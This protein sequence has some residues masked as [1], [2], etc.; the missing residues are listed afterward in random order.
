VSLPPPLPPQ[1]FLLESLGYLEEPLAA[2]AL[3]I[4]LP[5]LIEY[6]KRGIGPDFAV[7]GR[8]IL[9]SHANLQTWLENGGTRAFEHGPTREAAL[10]ER[11]K[12]RK[13]KTAKAGLSTESV[14]VDSVQGERRAPTSRIKRRSAAEVPP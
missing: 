8:T 2:I 7:V 13:P 12:T 3:D 1:G 14:L 9:Y 10:A 11:P 6:R 4:R 5:T